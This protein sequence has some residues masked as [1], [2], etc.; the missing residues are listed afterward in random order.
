MS[1]SFEQRI[2]LQMKSPNPLFIAWLEEWLKY[3]EQKNSLKRHSLAK[4]LE[5]LQKYPLIM[6]TGRDC[7]ILEGFGPGICNMIDKQLLVY[8]TKH[9]QVS[10]ITERE[11]NASIQEVIKKVQTKLCERR[12]KASTKSKAINFTSDATEKEIIPSNSSSS[13]SVADNRFKFLFLPNNFD[14]IFLVDTQETIGLVHER[15]T[16]SF[17]TI[18]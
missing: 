5:S 16:K 8:Q 9:K 15:K 1:T 7:S 2:T 12:K 10:T 14:I 13:T 4:A 17:C 3:A 6:Y 11:H 18:P